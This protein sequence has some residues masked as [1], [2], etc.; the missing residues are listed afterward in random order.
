M[1]QCPVCGCGES[2]PLYDGIVR[3]PDCSHVYA[4]VS[5][6]DEELRRLYAREYFFGEEYSD[7]LADQRIIEKNFEL[8][9]KVLR[10]HL[11]RARHRKLLEVGCAYGFFLNRARGD[12]E[13]VVGY[14]ITE[15]G[16][17]HAREKL[18]L[19]ARQEDFLAADLKSEG[20]DVA[21]MW[22]TIEHL[23]DPARF[24]GKVAEAAA[25]GALLA[26]T[27][28]DIGSLNARMRGKSWRLIHP[29]THLHYFTRQS[30]ERMLA[31]H[32]YKVIHFEHC[33]F[34]R[35][36][37]MTMYNILVLRSKARWLYD[38]LHRTPLSRLDFYLNL[39]DV[40]YV[41]ARKERPEQAAAA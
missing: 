28:G 17:R 23:R 20:F 38:L 26:I 9:L 27:T 12:F 2:R 11:D 32:G 39:G 8:R 13:K 10:K 14:D 41:I 4:D 15:E 3:C 31:A 19:D 6:S 37:D 33:G 25:P 35:S 30:M 29:P 18:G 1:S 22:D 21:C 5:V 36:V 34:S 40:M 7:Y 16:V 24:V